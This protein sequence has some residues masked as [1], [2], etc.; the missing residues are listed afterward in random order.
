M[1]RSRFGTSRSGTPDAR[2]APSGVDIAGAVMRPWVPLVGGLVAVALLLGFYGVVE[3]AVRR[4]DQVHREAKGSTL[5][6]P[7][8][9]AVHA[10]L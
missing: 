3:G 7:S 10:S 9:V 4:A 8:T 1:Q 5:V 6:V 2:W